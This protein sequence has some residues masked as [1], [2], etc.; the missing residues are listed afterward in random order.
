[1]AGRLSTRT[2]LIAGTAVVAIVGASGEARAGGFYV[3]EQSAYFQGMSFAGAAAGGPAL[4][5][6]FWNPATITQHGRGLTA[7]LNGSFIIGH[8]EIHPSVATAPTG[9]SLLGLGPSRDLASNALAPSTYVVYGFSDRI[10]I[11]LGLNSPFGLTTKP[12]QQWA[13]LFYSRESHAFSLNANPTVAVKIADWLSVGVGAQV[14]Y[15]KVK[16]ESGFPGSGSFPPFG[17]LVPDNLLLKAQSWDLGFTAGVTIT[18]GPWTTIGLGYRSGV[19]HSLEGGIF[20][21]QFVIP[22]PPALT[23]VPFAFRAL[24]VDVPLPDIA[25]ASIRQRVSESFTVLGSVEWTNWSRMTTLPLVIT[26]AAPF[27]PTSLPFEWRDGWMVSVGGEYQFS[28]KMMLR[29]GIAWESSPVTDDV[30]GTRL[31]DTDRL[32]LSVGATYNWN[33]RLALELAYSHLFLDD[34]PINLVPG[35]PTFNASLGTFI[36]TAQ[37]QID[38]ISFAL[39]YRFGGPAAVPPA[40]LITKG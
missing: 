29:A 10:S 6:M 5:A 34:A 35:N 11:G 4:S 12:G 33:E 21:P 2:A 15:F 20:R 22:P 28:P 19:D 30:R 17:P 32:W 31:P 3:H 8:S 40:P 38:I 14:Q 37:T 16:L 23:V 26:P 13:G 1:M 25:M 24:G 18:P 39:R 36:G 9:A 27:A 7:E